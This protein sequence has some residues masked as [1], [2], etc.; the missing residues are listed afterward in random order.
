MAQR[1]TP[2]QRWLVGAIS[3]VVAGIVALALVL[4]FHHRPTSVTTAS[5][6]Q[7]PLSATTV[8]G[9][10]GGP[11]TATTAAQAPSTPH[12]ATPQAAMDYLTAAWNAND[13]VA[14]DHV[15]NPAAR[16]ELA[17]M[18]SEAVNLRLNHCNP[19]PAGDYICYFDHDYPA[20]TATT[21]GGG[22]GHAVFLAGPAARPGWYMTVFI[23][24][25]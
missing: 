23:T 11:V 14:L 13:V 4:A 16:S 3:A 8:G 25:G 17:S 10:S 9:T 5:G 2:R 1:Y 24:C 7:A 21:L 15:T 20:G 22:V 12:F 18:H 19:R 6:G